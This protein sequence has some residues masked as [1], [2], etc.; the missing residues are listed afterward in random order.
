MKKFFYLMA[1]LSLV[2]F[3]S[4]AQNLDSEVDTELEQM[5]G[6]KAS[7]VK[8]PHASAT[9]VSGSQPIYILN[10]APAQTQQQVP[11]AAQAASVQKQPTTYIQESPLVESPA[12]QMKKSRQN[13]EVETE[14]RI[15][16]K[17]E[18]S[19]IDDE[20][21]R[22]NVLFGEQFNQLQNGAGQGA[23]YQQQQYAQS[24]NQ[25]QPSAQTQQAQPVQVQ[26]QPI[27]IQTMPAPEKENTRDVIR[28]EIRSA[29]KLE[30][31]IP[32]GPVQTR[33][34]SA[35][36][37]IADYPDARNVRG[38]YSL[39]ASFETR[40]DAAAVEGAFIYSNFTVDQVNQVGFTVPT[41]ID[42]RQYSAQLAAKYY[43]FQ[44][45]IRPV[46]GGVMAY[47]YREF[48]W[49]QNSIYG[50]TDSS[51]TGTSH[52]IDVGVLTGADI[53]F[54]STFSL[55]VDFRY[56]WNMSSR[57]NSNSSVMNGL[58]YGTP[59]EKLQ[60]YVLSVSGRVNF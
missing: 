55:G 56:L 11:S 36:V 23:G 14:N 7:T 26:P 52:A 22:A 32:V 51:T 33:Y 41:S 49:S 3:H 16:L 5:Y 43:L 4:I 13:A 59:I 44:G 27:V 40:W 8:V 2:P 30:E 38:N 35:L 31:D 10:Q 19:R 1:A 47:N 24:Q 20:K 57:V 25:S 48:G 53:A 21:R 12:D 60:H 39:G 37:G 42:V 17:L 29:M 28:E 6:K 58:A 18:Q 54:S 34:F 50:Q 46:V 9:T 15:V 45:L